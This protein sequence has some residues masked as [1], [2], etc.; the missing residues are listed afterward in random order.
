MSCALCPPPGVNYATLLSSFF[1]FGLSSSSPPWRNLPA[2]CLCPTL[3]QESAH[4][5]CKGTDI[6]HW[7]LCG[8]LQS[9][10]AP[11]PSLHLWRGHRQQM[12][13]CG[14]HLMRLVKTG[15]RPGLTHSPE[16]WLLLYDLNV[17][18]YYS[19]NKSLPNR[20]GSFICEQGHRVSPLS[21]PVLGADNATSCRPMK[22]KVMTPWPQE[23][24][25]LW[26]VLK[27]YVSVFL[28]SCSG[29]FMI[30]E[31]NICPE[32]PLERVP[33]ESHLS[34]FK[35]LLFKDTWSLTRIKSHWIACSWAS[36]NHGAL[37][38]FSS[39]FFLLFTAKISTVK[40]HLISII[41]MSTL[42]KAIDRFNTIPMKIPTAPL[43]ELEQ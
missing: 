19:Y 14:Y 27:A 31:Q 10:P 21:H 24:S 11:T 3:D 30:T 42:P 2:L 9:V 20:N 6:E 8:P 26:L 43:T 1:S 39:Y 22:G 38:S 5:L 15:S 12:K 33:S 29:P 4:L 25:K 7:K 13:G 36:Q 18:W 32:N 41:K 37:Q 40:T 34:E 35:I 28:V 17:R 16:C 23:R